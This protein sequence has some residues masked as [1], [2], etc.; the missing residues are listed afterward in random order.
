MQARLQRAYAGV[1]PIWRPMASGG[2]CLDGTSRLAAAR[3]LNL[4]CALLLQV[5]V[6]NEAPLPAL[7]ARD[8]LFDL[9]RAAA[10]PS[11][12]GKG[13]KPAAGAG[14]ASASPEG[15][16]AAEA[17]QGAAAAEDGQLSMYDRQPECYFAAR[18]RTTA[19]DELLAVGTPLHNHTTKD[20]RAAVMQ[21]IAQVP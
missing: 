15:G 11:G 3:C 18:M 7:T 16:P 12:A 1:P 10:P 14:R 6:P 2:I 17:G 9:P 8:A 13:G 19:Q 5:V 20:D 4:S 21:R